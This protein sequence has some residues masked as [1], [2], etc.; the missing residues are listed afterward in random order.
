MKIKALITGLCMVGTAVSAKA[1]YQITFTTYNV[2]DLTQHLVFDLD[3]TT[4]LTGPNF[5]GQLYVGANAGSLAAIGSP[6]A[7]LASGSGGEGFIDSGAPISVVSGSLNVNSSAVYVLRAWRA[8]DGGTYE[9]ASVVPGAHVG[10]SAVT[11]VTLGGALPPPS[12][13]V[14]AFPNAHASFSLSVVPVSVPEPSV[15]ALGLLGGAA[16]V[17]R[18]RK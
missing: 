4:K 6:V 18:R 7:F 8:S 9:A 3:G 16:L 15:L 1:D 14:E 12:L 5:L 10:S 13:P 11:P 17:L 2:S